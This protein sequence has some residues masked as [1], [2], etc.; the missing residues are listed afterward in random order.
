MTEPCPFPGA[1]R[2]ASLPVG[3]DKT[4]RERELWTTGW[5]VDKRRAPHGSRAGP[6]AGDYFLPILI[7]MDV[8]FTETTRIV[9]PV[10]GSFT[11]ALGCSAYQYF[12]VSSN[13]G[14]AA[15]PRM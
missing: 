6:F 3:T 15:W 14:T 5:A 8:P 10:A 11:P 9:V 4:G 7:F 2:H 13:S 12:L 1:T